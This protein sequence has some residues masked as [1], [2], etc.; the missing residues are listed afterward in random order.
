MGGGVALDIR[1]LGRMAKD[2]AL[3]W[4]GSQLNQSAAHTE[5]SRLPPALRTISSPILPSAMLIEYLHWRMMRS[6]QPAWAGRKA[7]GWKR[8][9]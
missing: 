9:G 6:H 4:W 5:W 3:D 7:R 2:H 1:A 8:N